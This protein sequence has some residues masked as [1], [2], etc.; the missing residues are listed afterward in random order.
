MDT[1]VLVLVVLFVGVL[2][3]TAFGWWLRR[4]EWQVERDLLYRAKDQATDA[5][6]DHYTPDPEDEILLER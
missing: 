4:Y 6:L 2:I 3:G 1:L 5:L